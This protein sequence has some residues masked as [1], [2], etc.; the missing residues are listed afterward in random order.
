MRGAEEGG[1]GRNFG[2]AGRGGVGGRGWTERGGVGGSEA[3]LRGAG[4]G[5]VRLEW[6]GR[7]RGRGRVKGARVGWAV[8][9]WT[10]NGSLRLG[11]NEVVLGGQQEK[12][13][14]YRGGLLQDI[15]FSST[16]PYLVYETWIVIKKEKK[17]KARRLTLTFFPVRARPPRCAELSLEL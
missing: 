17:E 5:A 4:S 15:I 9:G 16:A 12:R 1:S 8:A 2:V 7:G 11:G 6:R 10:G 3:G 13:K 14:N